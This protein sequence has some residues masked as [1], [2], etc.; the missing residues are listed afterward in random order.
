MPEVEALKALGA[1]TEEGL[2]RC[3]NNEAFYLRLVGMA[4]ADDKYGK[5]RAAVEAGDLTAGFEYAH[6]LKG[7]LANVALTNLLA[8]IAEMTEALIDYC[9]DVFGLHRVNAVCNPENT[10]SWHVLEKCGMTREAYLRKKCRYEKQG[11]VSWEDELEY[12]ILASERRIRKM[13]KLSEYHNTIVRILCGDGTVVT[14]PC[15]WYPSGYGLAEFGVEEEL[16]QIGDTVVFADEIREIEMLRREVCIPVRDWPEAKEEIAAWFHERWSIPLE[17]YRESIRACLGEENG[18]P[19]W[20]VV[21]RGSR[22]I[23]G[24]GVIA[25]DFHER[26]DLTPNVCAVYVDEAY[27]RQGIA[28]FMLRYVCEDMAAMGFPTLYLLTDLIGFY[29]R[30]GWRFACMALGDDGR[31]SRMYVHRA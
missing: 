4:L 20:Y 21:V 31:I 13:E 10:A 5:L 26:K 17:T 27:R 2:G 9:F 28:G 22:I 16:L 30:Y 7:M 24:C 18:L 11:V 1:N 25:N 8:P 19:Q 12:A 15:E 6:A 14:G 29:E 3:L 23:A